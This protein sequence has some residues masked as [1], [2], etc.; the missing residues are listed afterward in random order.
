[1][2]GAARAELAASAADITRISESEEWRILGRWKRGAFGGVKSDIISDGFFLAEDGRKNPEA[3]LRATLAGLAAPMTEQP[4]A[5]VL[6]R[7]P[8]RATFLRQQGL[9]VADPLDQCPA[10]SEFLDGGATD[11][12]SVLFISGYLSNPGSAFGH[13]LMRFH[14]AGDDEP[15]E[16]VLDRAINYGAASSED[17]ALLPYLV[18]GLFG[19]YQSTYSTIQFYHQAQRYREIELRTI[20]QYRLDLTPEET[21]LVTAHV[22]ELL[23][24]EN[25]YYF[26]R[27]NCAY[28]IAETLELVV[29]RDLVPNTKLWVTPID[30]FHQLT[31]DEAD[32]GDE[33]ADFKRL[34]SRETLFLEG[35]RAL[36]ADGRAF[37]DR[38]IAA[39]D[40]SVRAT[41]AQAPL[42]DP[43]AAYNVLLDHYAY[44]A[45]TPEEDARLEEVTIE[46]FKL[47]PSTAPVPE[48]QVPP[49]TG[50]R[51]SL[52]QVSALANDTLGEG[53]ELRIRPAY[54]DFLSATV[55]TVPYSELA[56]ADTRLVI[57]DGKVD[58]RSL[59][60]VRVTNLSPR[61][62][63]APDA[64][65]LAWRVRFGAE[66]RDLACD[67][68]L[69][70]YGE[71][72]VGK[73]Y[74][75]AEGVALYG[76][77]SGRIEAG[78]HSESLAHIRPAAG[79]VINRRAAA[80]QIEGGILQGLDEDDESRL[81]GK[82]ELRLG[83]GQRWD[84]R[85][86]TAYDEALET[87]F[88]L[89]FYW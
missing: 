43:S 15:V 62:A 6:C 2:S 34:A 49:H 83:A 33:I 27:Q 88:S 55:G 37:V 8:G 58:L 3:E 84:V 52:V 73:A 21:R 4:E 30:V 22:Y 17:D 41:L 32:G 77:V 45:D 54:F 61:T 13:L 69:L 80:F 60:A 7:Y 71:F 25:R 57:R 14:S 5:H 67:Q 51:P 74:E 42:D 20:W 81:F 66:D 19:G 12:V 59:E 72:G 35:Y 28:R 68:C 46:R 44:A 1:M 11:S 36:E 18:K 38:V 39:P 16:N 86:S 70:G 48:R 9:A 23:K 78:R 85:V 65:G 50:Q 76:L 53:T 10:F 63:D 87:A 47:P 89:G 64:G 31:G 29:D 26:M 75:L 82:A 79:F 24:S 56:M 40:V